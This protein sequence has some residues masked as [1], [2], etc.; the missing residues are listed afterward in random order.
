MLKDVTFFRIA[1]QLLLFA[2]LASCSKKTIIFETQSA[3]HSISIDRNEYYVFENDSLR[4][5]YTFWA[6]RGSMAFSIYNKLEVPLYINW[7]RSSLIL[8][9]QKTD[10]WADETV[11]SFK[12]AT[13]K[14]ETVD[15]YDFNSPLYQ[16][17]SLTSS[18][19][20]ASYIQQNSIKPEKVTFIAPKSYIFKEKDG[21]TSIKLPSNDFGWRKEKFDPKSGKKIKGE[22]VSFAE[23]STPIVFRNFLSI[24]TN[25][26]F[27]RESYIDHTFYVNKVIRVKSKSAWS[28]YYDKRLKRTLTV[29]I[30]YRPISFY[31]E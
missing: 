16:L 27:T 14:T 3:N 19:T 1:I 7:K 13:K 23:N 26:E 4:M 18:T 8:N 21:L 6:N 15:F 2:S 30:F 20:S 31:Q 25:E 11:V 12:K 9:A 28:T 17:M 22:S 5:V 24:S 10:Y 29:N